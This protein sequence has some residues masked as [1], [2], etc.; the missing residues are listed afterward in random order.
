[1]RFVKTPRSSVITLLTALLLITPGCSGRKWINFI[2]QDNVSYNTT[3][4]SEE[5]ELIKA[6]YIAVEQKVNTV[7]ESLERDIDDFTTQFQ[8]HIDKTVQR[9]KRAVKRENELKLPL[10]PV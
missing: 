3:D 8:R 7:I 9:A 10:K 5:P 2:E 1:M 4:L 6:K